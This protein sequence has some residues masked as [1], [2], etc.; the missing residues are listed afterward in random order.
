[1]IKTNCTLQKTVLM[2]A[3]ACA[4]L[5]GAQAAGQGLR[6]II[7]PDRV[8]EVGSPVIGVIESISVE[9][10]DYVQEGQ[11]LARLR[12]GV[13]RAFVSA[14]EVRA[15]AE[16]D[17]RAARVNYEYLHQKQVRAEDLVERNFISKQAL[18]QLRAEAR[19]AEQ[20]LAQTREQR[21]IAKQELDLA[22]AQLGQ[23][24]I[25][26]PFAGIIAE[27][28]VTVGERID[29][30]P[31]FRV[32]K[33]NPLRVEVIVPA[34]H[35]GTIRVGM[36]ARLTPDLPSAASVDAKIVLVDKLVDA[37]SNTFRV[38]GELPNPKSAV[39][40]G[41][42]CKADLMEPADR[43]KPAP[44]ATPGSERPAEKLKAGLKMDTGIV[45]R[46]AK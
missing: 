15:Q 37:A 24:S 9:R 28:Y 10:G 11:L 4:P 35:F 27:R 34:A 6:C 7:E 41:L 43:I 13:E 44:A 14:A 21:S 23:R 20:K 18:D 12:A 3:L 40:S 8:A 31:M 25:R 38:R 19:V 17:V 46:E 22:R 39:P 5:S 42:R 33:I 2:F 1:M 32:A 16:A 45:I 26:A 30:K 36:I 29:E